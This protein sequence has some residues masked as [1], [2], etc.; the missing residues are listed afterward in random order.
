MSQ[1]QCPGIIFHRGV[2]RQLPDVSGRPLLVFLKAAS[3]TDLLRRPVIVVDLIPNETGFLRKR[4]FP[5]LAPVATA[6]GAVPFGPALNLHS[7]C[8]IFRVFQREGLEK[9][10]DGSP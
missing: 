2:R 1:R 4:Y 7:L 5:I 8:K 3:I 6:P 10:A 9:T